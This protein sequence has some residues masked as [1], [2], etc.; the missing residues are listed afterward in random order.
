MELICQA[1]QKKA[2][3][4]VREKGCRIFGDDRCVKMLEIKALQ[5]VQ[6]S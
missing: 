2:M 6:R 1:T 5:E 3:A 4:T